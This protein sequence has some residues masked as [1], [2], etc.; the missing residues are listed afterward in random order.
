MYAA[1]LALRGQKGE[2]DAERSSALGVA[3]CLP[4]L[5]APRRRRR[6]RLS[7]PA[8]F[9]LV[10]YLCNSLLPGYKE[11]RLRSGRQCNNAPR[12][13]RNH[14]GIQ[15]HFHCESNEKTLITLFAHSSTRCFL[16]RPFIFPGELQ[17]ECISDDLPRQ[18]HI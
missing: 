4:L 6:I 17:P 15:I 9:H 3:F 18:N 11:L 7:L 16:S 1:V 12:S 14:V 8:L 5:A 13:P 2:E 10:S